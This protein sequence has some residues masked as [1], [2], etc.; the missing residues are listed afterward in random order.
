MSTASSGIDIKLGDKTYKMSALTLGGFKK[1]GS[2]VRSKNIE[3]AAELIKTLPECP[4]RADIVKETL[5]PVT[6]KDTEAFMTTVDGGLYTAWTCLNIN[7]PE[8]THDKFISMLTTDSI[9]EMM[10]SF[11]R[12]LNTEVGE[13]ISGE[14]T[15]GKARKRKQEGNP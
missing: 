6:D 3:K 11:Q 5:K 7:H 2:Y 8:L 9:K 14:A 4:E 13:T 1:I 12:L 10:T 15:E